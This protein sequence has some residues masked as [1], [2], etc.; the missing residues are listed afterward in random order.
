MRLKTEFFFFFVKNG[1]KG[2][3]DG[4]VWWETAERFWQI[5][6]KEV[7]W[8]EREEGG[9]KVRGRGGGGEKEVR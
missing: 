7:K 5:N 2:T 8:T 9:G 6:Q 1:Q 4:R 3:D